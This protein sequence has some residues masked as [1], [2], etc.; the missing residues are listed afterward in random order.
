MEDLLVD[1][2]LVTHHEIGEP[3][4]GLRFAAHARAKDRF[5]CP[6]CGTAVRSRW[7]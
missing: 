6:E 5:A 3:D 1:G 4:T 7:M 2:R